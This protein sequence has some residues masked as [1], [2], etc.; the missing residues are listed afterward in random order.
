[1]REESGYLPTGRG[2]LFRV[3]HLPAGAARTA[4]LLLAPGADER[5]AAHGTLVRL[6]RALSGAGAAVMRF[7]YF[8]TGDSA[9]ESSDVT[10]SGMEADATAA[11]AEL[12]RLVPDAPLCLAGA[13]LGASLALVL[14]SAL[15]AGRVAAVAPVT[16]GRTW[17]RQ[18]RGRSRLRRSMVAAAAKPGP[19]GGAAEGVEDLDGLPLSPRLVAELDAF[20]PAPC[21]DAAALPAALVMQV[22]PR[23]S[24]LPETEALAN[25]F[26][27]A[28]A[29]LRLEP[30]WQP[31][32]Q[33]DL[34][35]LPD[36][37]ERFLLE[38]RA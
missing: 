6:A 37:L 5:R 15:G 21:A 24:P 18:E 23:S 38:E 27:A 3:L 12:H 1:V 19:A 26:G 34:G 16:S 35:E 11:A 33:T 20:E 22:S 2:A 7:D 10:L 28:V 29:C 32:E 36:C 17:L 4:V 25:R 8:G 31:L 13:R 30:F 14:G 9:G